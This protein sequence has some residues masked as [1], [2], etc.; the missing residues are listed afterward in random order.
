MQLGMVGLGRM[1][2]NIV[3]R[4]MKKGHECVAY[5]LQPESVRGLEREGARGAASLDDLVQKLAPP[6]AIW[7]MVPSGSP[8]EEIVQALGQRLQAGDVLIDGGN[9][10]FK[11]DVRRSPAPRTL[12][13]SPRN[14][15]CR[16][17]SP[18]TTRTSTSTVWPGRTCGRSVLS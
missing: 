6:R 11:D 18:S 7:I 12:M 5:D 8:T 17:L 14:F 13:I 1:G 3:R 4:L 15:C 2:A 10:Y 16:S 9:S